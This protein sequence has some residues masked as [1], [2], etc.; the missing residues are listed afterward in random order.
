MDQ[1]LIQ[2]LMNE[3]ALGLEAVRSTPDGQ[4]SIDVAVSDTLSTLLKIFV[5][6]TEFTVTL[7]DGVL[8]CQDLR[9]NGSD[10]EATAALVSQMQKKNIERITFKSGATL[11][12]V[13]RFYELLAGPDPRPSEQDRG[14]DAPFMETIVFDMQKAGPARQTS[15][16]KSPEQIIRSIRDLVEIVKNRGSISDA[17]GPFLRV[18][19]DIE[20]APSRD[21]NSY[22]EALASVVELL[23]LEKRVALM[24]DIDLQPFVVML[25]S[26]LQD[27]TLV[28]LMVNWDRQGR[29][30]HVKRTLNIIDKQRLREIIPILKARQIKIYQY[31]F[32]AGV[33]L[34][35]EDSIAS[36]IAEADLK[37]ALQP[38]YN[39]LKADN[40]GRRIDA[41]GSLLNFA[42]RM[43]REGKHGI[44]AAVMSRVAP[45]IEGEPDEKVIEQ[46]LGG[47]TDLYHA[48]SANDAR[49]AC[50]SLIETVGRVLGRTE[51]DPALR[52]RMIEYLSSTGN[53]S[54]LP[55]L[56]SLL[57]ES[58]LYPDVRAAIMS[59]RV[60]AVKEA[61]QLLRYAEEFAL[62]MK[63]IDLLKNMGRD[64]ID[65]LLDNLGAREWFLRRNIVRIFGE[66][67]DPSVSPR[68][69]VVFSDDD[70]RVRLELV[71]AFGKLNYKTGLLRSLE[72]TSL[73]VKSEALRGLRNLI[74]TEEFIDLLDKLGA[75]GDE[76]YVELLKIIDE[77]RVLEAMHWISD[78]LKRLEWRSDGPANELR[79]L[80]VTTL[81]RL[82]SDEARMILLDL[83][84]SGD[85]K[86]AVLA[87]NALKRFP[88]ARSNGS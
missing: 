50:D 42:V 43:T 67:G 63:L 70:Y 49:G 9:V 27:E 6:Q 24:Q 78:M 28:E 80:A 74:D 66:I 51:L 75:S 46:C 55:I 45:A 87:A 22:R 17:M 4:S 79:E 85:K 76:V 2:E 41:Y 32:H 16:R 23:P 35:V 13:S 40:A 56:F 15:Q 37:T 86:L 38:Y 69:E 72:D 57:W 3:I 36:S 44:S 59:Y 33:N 60:L 61:V 26:R 71:R 83:R 82:N 65:A 73:L 25:L 54:A 81:A 88:D 77:K 34:L 58:G 19:T 39:M 11:Q 5:D 18:V 7:S 21:W 68:L 14:A 31:L 1:G 20:N 62:R 84:N 10:D 47:L 8:F 12:D 30:D 29:L 53:P 64:S 48:C 52:R